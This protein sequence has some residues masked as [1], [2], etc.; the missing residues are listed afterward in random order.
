MCRAAKKERANTQCVIY[1]N[2]NYADFG[3]LYLENYRADCYEIYI[4]YALHE[5][6]LPYQIGK[7]SRWKFARYSFSKVVW[8]SSYF[9]LLLRTKPQTISSRTK[10]IFTSF[11]FLQIWY[12]YAGLKGLQNLWFWWNLKLF[13]ASY[14]QISLDIFGNLLSRLPTR[15]LML[16]L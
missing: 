12:T 15:A 4:F 7:K 3:L 11:D 13:R 1:A 16:L 6:D 9:F 5:H 8:F 14:K 2:Q 10:T